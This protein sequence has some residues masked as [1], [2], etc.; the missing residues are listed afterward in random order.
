[1]GTSSPPD[2]GQLGIGTTRRQ[3]LRLAGN[4]LLSSGILAACRPLAGS[5]EPPLLQISG[6][7]KGPRREV[8]LRYL[9][10]ST[11]KVEQLIGDLDL[12]TKRPTSNQTYSRYSI[13]GTDLGYS[14]EHAGKVFF[15]FGDTLGNQGGD[16]I[17]ASTSTDPDAPLLLD[18]LTGFS[19]RYLKLEPESTS[20]DGFEVP[21]GGISIA[22]TMYVA[23]KTNHSR[24]A[25]TD[26][27][28]LTRFDETRRRF[29]VVREISR[30]PQ[31]RFITLS[32]RLVAAGQLPELSDEAEV[33]MF[34][35]GQYRRS[36]LYLAAT[37]AR[38]FGSGAGTRY[39]MGMEGTKPLWTSSES[40]AVP[41][42]DHA[43]I[44]DVSV[45]YVPALAIWVALYDSRTPRGIVMRYAAQP[46]GPWSLPQVIFDLQRDRGL[47]AF[48][49]NPRLAFDDGLGGPV[50]G[51]NDPL[52]TS[53]GIYAPYLIERFTRVVQQTLTLHYVLSTWNPYVVVRMRSSFAVEAVSAS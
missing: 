17:A 47:G 46:W 31:G 49:H 15:L 11:G 9:D 18:F 45:A 10:E 24:E 39:F 13:A 8:R 26:I 1:M 28:L 2:L 48:I 42:I 52:K 14:F 36:S 5:S 6:S 4:L 35:S 30:L 7:D 38:S 51:P 37:R 20:M 50:I 41:I 34:G 12:E 43:T 25:P 32:L 23:V 40:E 29:E 19:G 22:G 33:L 27:S 16:V 3:A 21:V 53:G 44:G